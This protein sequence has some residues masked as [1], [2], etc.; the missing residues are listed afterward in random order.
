MTDAPAATDH[1]QFITRL[2]RSLDDGSFVRLLLGRPHGQAA[3][4]H[5]LLARHTDDRRRG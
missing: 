5:K 3:T 2:Q 4:L 1:Q